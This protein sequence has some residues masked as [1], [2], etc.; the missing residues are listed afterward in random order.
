MN[1]HANFMQLW[2]A[3]FPSCSD[4]IPRLDCLKADQF[5]TVNEQRAALEIAHSEVLSSTE[6]LRAALTQQMFIADYLR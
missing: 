1:L 5:L 3:K 6:N 4:S 2:S